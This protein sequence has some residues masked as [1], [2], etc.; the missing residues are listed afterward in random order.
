MPEASALA[1]RKSVFVQAPIEKAFE[2]FT[3]DIGSWWPHKTH[4][5]SGEKAVSV[6]METRMGGRLFETDNEGTEHDWG[7]ITAWEPPRR[8]VDEQLVVEDVA[9]VL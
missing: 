6:S 7:V 2:V 5:I 9:L 8:F 1:V 3:T 4:S